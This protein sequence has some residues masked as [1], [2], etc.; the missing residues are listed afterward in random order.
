MTTKFLYAAVIAF[1]LTAMTSCKTTNNSTAANAPAAGENAFAKADRNQDGKL[2]RNETND[3]FV[4][5]IFEGADQNHDGNVT[6][7]EWDVPGS[8][9]TKARFDAADT[10]KDGSVSLTEAQAFGQKQGTFNKEFAEADTNHDGY[11]TQ[12]EAQEYYAS[13]EGPPR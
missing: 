4:A 6:W 3:Y 1:I 7:K 13:K 8:G 12:E 11:V 10:N 9:R 5:K 2:S